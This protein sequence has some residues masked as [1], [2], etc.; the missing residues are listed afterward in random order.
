MN[1]DG[2]LS[3]LSEL[4]RFAP[5]L[6]RLYSGADDPAPFSWA[7]PLFNE[8]DASLYYAMIRHFRPKRILEVG[9]GY[10]T[11]IAGLAATRNG[12]VILETIEP[13]PS[14]LLKSGVP[15][16][17]TLIEQRVQDVPVS[18]F[19]VLESGDILFIDS[20]H[21]CK[22]G[23]DVNFLFFRVLPALKPGVVVHMHDIFLRWDMPREWITRLH[24]FWTEQYLLLAFLQGNRGFEVL[25][26]SHYLGRSHAGKTKEAFPYLNILGGCS[27]WMRRTR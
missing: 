24:L 19:E 26:G 17:T 1:Q 9:G 20:T 25:I 7:N 6:T 16:L 18:S 5:E 27:F 11:S 12:D 14:S 3:L 2:Q 15:G 8:V 21:V 22:T 10:S 4:G 23:S 13:Y